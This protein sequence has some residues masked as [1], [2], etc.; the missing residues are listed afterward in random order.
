[1]YGLKVITDNLAEVDGVIFGTDTNR[2]GTNSNKSTN[3]TKNSDSIIGKD[4][5]L[6]R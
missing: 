3:V 4:D 6:V 2:V 5:L 1:M